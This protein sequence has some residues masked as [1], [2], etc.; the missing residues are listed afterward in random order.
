MLKCYTPMDFRFNR[1]D[2]SCFSLIRG[3][4]NRDLL[5]AARGLPPASALEHEGRTL[6]HR[7]VEQFFGWFSEI[8][9]HNQVCKQHVRI[10]G[11]SAYFMATR[12]RAGCTGIQ[13]QV[14]ATD[15][16]LFQNVQTGSGAHPALYSMVPRCLQRGEA[17]GKWI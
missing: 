8:R 12:V 13:I 11:F 15:F 9:T 7:N 3:P 2:A 6:P 14:G 5:P 16:S 10:N 17:A 4:A 1:Q